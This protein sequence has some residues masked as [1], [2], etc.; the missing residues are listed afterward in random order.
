V[1]KFAH[2]KGCPWSTLTC[3]WQDT[4]G[5]LEVIKYYFELLVQKREAARREQH[6]ED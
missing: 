5:H 6:T 3:A 1:L 4:D 2:E